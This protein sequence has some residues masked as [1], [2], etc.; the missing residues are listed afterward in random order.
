MFTMHT[1]SGVD[2]EFKPLS[3]E[4]KDYTIG[5]CWFFAKHAAF[6]SKTGETYLPA[7][8]W[9]SELAI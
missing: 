8:N 1:S 6:K 3:G 9:F 7:D 2:H 5:I 4:T